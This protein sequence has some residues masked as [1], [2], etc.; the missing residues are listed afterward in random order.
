VRPTLSAKE[1][2]F[3]PLAEGR[4]WRR[5]NCL[6]SVVTRRQPGAEISPRTALDP[7]TVEY[8]TSEPRM[9]RVDLLRLSCSRSVVGTGGRS[10]R[11]RLSPRRLLFDAIA[12]KAV[13]IR[14][15]TVMFRDG[16]E[17]GKTGP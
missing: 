15:R 8:R 3:E 2:V 4:L 7:E 5:S 16:N 11:I 12:G 17:T 10:A 1:I 13:V 9:L 6:D 14:E